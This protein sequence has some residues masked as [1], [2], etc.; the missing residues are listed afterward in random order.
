MR[1]GWQKIHQKNLA[2]IMAAG[3]LK[4]IKIRQKVL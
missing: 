3:N 4:L 1:N 2:A